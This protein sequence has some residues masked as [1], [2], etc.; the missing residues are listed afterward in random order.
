MGLFINYLYNI[1]IGNNVFFG[2]HSFVNICV[3]GIVVGG[4]M[5]FESLFCQ[6]EKYVL[7]IC[8]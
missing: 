1:F 5:N 7:V 6:G 4:G 2:L 8:L 3:S